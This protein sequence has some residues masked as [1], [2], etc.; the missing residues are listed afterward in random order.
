MINMCL[1]LNIYFLYSK[2]GSGILAS[3]KMKYNMAIF[4]ILIDTTR[5]FM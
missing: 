2:T 3:L 5:F 1:T 4:V